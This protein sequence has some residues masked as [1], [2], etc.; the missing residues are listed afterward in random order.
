MSCLLSFRSE[1]SF[2]ERDPRVVEL[3]GEDADKEAE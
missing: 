3:E 2:G 1:P